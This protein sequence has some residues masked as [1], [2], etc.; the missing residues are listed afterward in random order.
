MILKF[1]ITTLIEVMCV[2]L[3]IY[4][5]TKEDKL[6]ALEEAAEDKAA[7]WVADKII[8]HRERVKTNGR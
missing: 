5:F 8:K 4:G 1:I 2:S 6:I 7:R 3:I